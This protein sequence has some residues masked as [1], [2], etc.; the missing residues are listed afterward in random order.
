MP[1]TLSIVAIILGYMWV[2]DPLVDAPGP[3][4]LVAGVVVLS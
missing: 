2:A 4:P 1:Y 3:W